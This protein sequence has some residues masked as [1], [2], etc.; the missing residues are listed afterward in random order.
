MANIGKATTKNGIFSL[1]G[2]YRLAILI[3]T[4]ESKIRLKGK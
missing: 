2:R 4:K 1:I 3:T